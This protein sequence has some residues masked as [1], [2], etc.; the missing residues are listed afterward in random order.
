MSEEQ[1]TRHILGNIPQGMVWSFYALTALATAWAGW[2]FYR[3]F[4]ARRAAP[5]RRHRLSGWRGL[6]RAAISAIAYVTFQRQLLRD[7]FAGVAHL[8]TF[9]GFLVLF[10]GTCLVFLE[11]DTP[12]HFFYGWF[13]RIASLAIDLGGVAFM[14]GLVMFLSRRFGK[15][16]SRI[17]PAWRVALL[18]WLLLAIGATGFLLE[19]ARIARGLPDFEKWSFVGY[20]IAVLLRTAGLTEQAA[21]SGH[22]LLWGA[23]ALLCVGF[24][25]L[26]PWKFFSHMAYGLASWTTRSNEPIALL[27]AVDLDA[28]RPKPSWARRRR[29]RTCRSSWA[30][31]PTCRRAFAASFG[32]R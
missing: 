26:L 8:L 13:Y 29:C 30:C 22:R 19:G 23:H 9:H 1:V 28:G 7:R 27:K 3:R 17:L 2:R 31:T 32:C 15:R 11:H 12:L 20:A 5:D 24:F 6:G 18:A 10:A 25:A 4:R 21:V 14:A 16:Q